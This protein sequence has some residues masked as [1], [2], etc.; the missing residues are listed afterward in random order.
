MF[1]AIKNLEV[2]LVDILNVYIPAPVI[3]KCTTLDPDFSKDAGE[4]AVIVR[5][6]Y[7]LKS[8]GVVFRS[9]CAKCMESM[10]CA[11]CKADNISSKTK[12]HYLVRLCMT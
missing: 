1:T 8:T 3:K 12:S 9:Y 11:S 5:A 4:T 7:D 2:E 6:L 10:E